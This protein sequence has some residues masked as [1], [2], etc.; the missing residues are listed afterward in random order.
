MTILNPTILVNGDTKTPLEG[1]GDELNETANLKKFVLDFSVQGGAIGAHQ[2][3]DDQG[4]PAVLPVGSIIARGFV[5]VVTAFTSGGSA[6]VALGCTAAN[7]ILAATAVA[8]LG[9]GLHECI[10]DGTAAAMVKVASGNTTLV[11]TNYST[12][13]QK[14]SAT[15]AVAALTAGKM[16]IYLDI[17]RSSL[18]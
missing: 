7:D 18:T 14:V 1:I 11:K 4:N 9:A 6:T 2:L 3:L 5:D 16:Y 13:A 10:Q 8:S 15:V 12:P 17:K